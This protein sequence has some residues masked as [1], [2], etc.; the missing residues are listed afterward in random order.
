MVLTQSTIITF[1]VFTIICV[2]GVT[3]YL[4]WHTRQYRQWTQ[5]VVSLANKKLRSP[6]APPSY[7]DDDERTQM[8][9]LIEAAAM[10]L[11]RSQQRLREQSNHLQMLFQ[12]SEQLSQEMSLNGVVNVTVESIWQAAE[13][14]FVAVLL[15]ENELGPFRYAGLRGS[16]SDPLGILDQECALPLWGVLAQALVNHPQNGEPDYL[17]IDDI[18]AEGRPISGEFP[19]E[20]QSG[21]LMVIPMRH[22][23]KTLGAILIGSRIPNYFSDTSLRH[24]LYAVAGITTRSIQEAQARQQSEQ[25]IKQLISLQ[26]LTRTII[27]THNLGRILEVLHDELADLFGDARIRI[28]LKSANTI[29]G[30]EGL[31]VPGWDEE[32]EIQL[33]AAVPVSQCEREQLWSSGVMELVRWV[34]AAEQPL[35]FDPDDTFEETDDLYYRVSGRGLLIPIGEE[36]TM[37]VLFVAAPNRA[38]PFEESDMIVVRTIAHS[39]AIAIG[40]AKLYQQLNQ[41][42]NGHL[43]HSIPNS[44]TPVS[45]TAES[46]RQQ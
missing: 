3:V 36:E 32:R 46:H 7:P 34:M 18:K 11:Q 43:L 5:E 39:A 27:R 10:H 42:R 33:F 16:V 13:I 8:L 23:S 30:A 1:L 26:T 37:G 20:A 24:Y 17:V 6:D 21:C 40:N 25:W 19:W 15:C 14:D 41:V 2:V 12:I 29:S 44:K 28:F 35:F 22:G 4:V 45:S 31:E 38:T 9:A